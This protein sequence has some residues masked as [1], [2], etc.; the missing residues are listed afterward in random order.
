[1][2]FNLSLSS[3][4]PFIHGVANLAQFSNQTTVCAPIVLISSSGVRNSTS[5]KDEPVP[6]QALNELGFHLKS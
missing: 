5:P 1:M 4:D 2:K 3:F 6:E